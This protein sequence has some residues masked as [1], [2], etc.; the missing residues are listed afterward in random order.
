MNAMEITTTIKLLRRRFAI[1][2]VAL[3]TLLCGSVVAQD[4]S[5]GPSSRSTNPS[6][7]RPAAPATAVLPADLHARA[8]H[9]VAS[10]VK[11]GAATRWGGATLGRAIPLYRPDVEGVAYYEVLVVGRDGTAAGFIVLSTGPH[12][13]PIVHWS[14]RGST[15]TERLTA[16]ARERNVSINRAYRLDVD[17][18]AETSDGASIRG[19][20]SIQLPAPIRGQRRQPQARALAAVEM[21]RAE[22]FTSWAETKTKYADAYR[23]YNDALR[24]SAAR[25]GARRDQGVPGSS[26][27]QVVQLM[28][29][30][31]FS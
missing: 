22:P 1:G 18:V 25:I 14:D 5:A 13:Y 7:Q 10:A 2:A 30:D 8:A 20:S 3:L 21:K 4:D 28:S 6:A 29:T 16:K 27:A 17:Y 26:G 9:H 23:E 24:L 19:E 11:A 15:P 12:D 31:T